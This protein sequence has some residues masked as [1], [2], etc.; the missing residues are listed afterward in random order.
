MT[1]RQKVVETKFYKSV[2]SYTQYEINCNTCKSVIYP[3]RWTE[4]IERVVEYQEKA[5]R[6][7]MSSTYI[8]NPTWVVIAAVGVLITAILLMLYL[9]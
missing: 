4:D 6:P 7:M 5:F 2:T 9:A 1:F 3:E 8:K